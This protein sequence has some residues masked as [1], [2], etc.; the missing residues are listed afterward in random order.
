M[1]RP[2]LAFL[3]GSLAGRTMQPLGLRRK[4]EESEEGSR[5]RK[6]APRSSAEGGGNGPVPVGGG[7]SSDAEVSSTPPL[8]LSEESDSERNDLA[9][10][11][12]GVV[13]LWAVG[14]G[15]IYAA[16]YFTGG[17]G[18]MGGRIAVAFGLLL[19]L[20]VVGVVLKEVLR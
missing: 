1:R 9:W 18:D 12:P 3:G 2:N 5:S 20:L 17:M 10:F 19:V 8:L 6:T 4:M 7:G 14:Y 11:V 13:V 15:S 16:E